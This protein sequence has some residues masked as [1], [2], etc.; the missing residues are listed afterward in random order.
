MS[1][2]GGRTMTATGI[3]L[4]AGYGGRL[5]PLTLEIPKVLLEVAGW[6]LIHYPISALWIAGV[7]DVAIIVGHKA[8]KG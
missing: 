2:K 1:E 4:A 5:R 3:I 7:T 6:P 8:A